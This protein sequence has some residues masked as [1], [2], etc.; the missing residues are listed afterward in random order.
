MSG[1]RRLRLIRR[2][3]NPWEVCWPTTN[4]RAGTIRFSRGSRPIHCGSRNLR[5]VARVHTFIASRATSSSL[6]ARAASLRFP[7][8]APGIP[9]VSIFRTRMARLIG[10]S[11]EREIG[12]DVERIRPEFAGEEIAK[13]YF[14]AN[15]I[16]GT[17]PATSGIANG[18][19]FPVL[20]SKGSLHQGAGEWTAHSARHL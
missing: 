20:D 8:M 13:R 14:S 1:A 6:M 15:E 4:G 17:T 5:D 12:I 9:F 11:R 16:S 10:I 18:R 7:A 3:C 19:I 2:Y